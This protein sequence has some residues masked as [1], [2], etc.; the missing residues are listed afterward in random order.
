M[1]ARAI[2]T[3]VN[4]RLK[5]LEVAYIL[6]HSGAS[7]LLIDHEYTQL[8]EGINVPM[9][10]SHDKGGVDDPYEEFLSLG[11]QFSLEKGWEGLDAE[12]HEDAGAVLCYT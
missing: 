11:R 1:A 8:V 3:P 6:E 10:I 2:I 7:L 12:R 4:T 5:P 9:I